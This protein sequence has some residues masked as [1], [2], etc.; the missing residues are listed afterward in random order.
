M[1]E[2][3]NANSK[4]EKKKLGFTLLKIWT[5]IW[6]IFLVPYFLGGSI[7]NLFFQSYIARNI[8]IL[9][10]EGQDVSNMIG[11]QVKSVKVIKG[12][13]LIRRSVVTEIKS[14]DKPENILIN[15]KNILEKNNWQIIK[16]DNQSIKFKN[17]FYIIMISYGV[18]NNSE[19]YMS[20]W[21]DF[22]NIF[23]KYNL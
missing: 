20:I 1:W 10:D 21:V 7:Y 17:D 5:G 22:N 23:T 13:A 19:Y 16:E 2:K 12:R 8:E 14:S 3:F 6:L 18:I 11:T 9:T 15:A 4:E